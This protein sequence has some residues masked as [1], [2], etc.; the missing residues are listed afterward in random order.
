MVRRAR[1]LALGG[2]TLGGLTLPACSLDFDSFL[3]TPEEVPVD[4][5]PVLDASTDIGIVPDE[6]PPPDMVIE[7]TDTDGDGVDDDTDNCPDVPNLDQ[8]DADGDGLGDLCD[9]DRDGD[10]VTN[11]LDNCPDLPNPD[12]LDLDGDGL[13]DAC[14]DDIDGD[15]L[16]NAQELTQGTDA[17]RPDTDADGLLDGADNCPTVPDRLAIDTD[18]DG[19]GD[20][21]DL[22][23][24]G[25]G[26]LDWADNC[27]RTVN[28]DQGDACVNDI[29]GDGV[30][31]DVDSCPTVANPDQAITPCVSRFATVGYVRDAYGLA[32]NDTTT[33]AATYGGALRIT[34]DDY[35]TLNNADGLVGNRLGRAVFDADGRA[36]FPT[37]RG[38]AVLRPD[39]VV[40][41]LPRLSAEG[42]QGQLRDVVADAGG[43]L[44]VATDNGLWLLSPQGLWSP[45]GP[46]QIPDNDVRSLY[47]DAQDRIWVATATGVVR[48]EG[49]QLQPALAGLPAVAPYT[50]VV[51]DGDRIWLLGEAGA[52][53]L[54]LADDAVGR[55]FTGF[56]ARGVSPANGGARYLATD[57]GI[58]R[59]D[60]D[61]RLFP[62]N[63]AQLPDP[64]VRDVRGAADAPRWL[65]TAGGVL[66]M[67]GHFSALH[68]AE[69]MPDPCVTRG[70]RI[71][72]YL[73]VTAPTGLFRINAD[74]VAAQVPPESLPAADTRVLRQ[75]ANGEVWVGTTGG[76]GVFADDGTP[77]R[78]LTN[79]DG[80]PPGTI[81][82]II[83]GANG[84]VWVASAANGVARRDLG[85]VWT[86]YTAETV[87]PAGNFVSNQVRAMAYGD[88]RVFVGTNVG[89]SVYNQAQDRFDPPVTNQNGV[90][91]SADINDLTSAGGTI[92]AGTEL[93]ISVRQP[94]GLWIN[95]FRN[96]GGLPLAAATDA[97]LA[98]AA[99][100]AYVWAVTRPVPQQQPNGTLVRR[101]V[102]AELGDQAAMQLFTADNAGLVASTL[103][104]GAA[105]D[106]RDG[107]LFISHCGN[108]QSP[109]GLTVLDGVRV[110]PRTL[111][112]VGV[113]G[114]AGRPVALVRGPDNRPAF[115]TSPDADTTPVMIS[116]GADG[117]RTTQF[118]PPAV[119]G[120]P[121][122]CD[123]NL[124]NASS[125]WCALGTKG[126]VQRRAPESWQ[127][128]R[129]QIRVLADGEARDI[130]VE[131]DVLVVVATNLGAVLLEDRSVRTFNR[132]GTAGGLPDDDVR[133]VR[134]GADGRLYFGTAAGVGIYERNTRQWTTI[135]V[136]V[137]ANADVRAL[138]VGPDGTV[139]VGT[140]SGVEKVGADLTSQRRIGVADGLPSANVTGIVV[141]GGQVYV[142]TEGG[143]ATGDGNGA[144]QVLG[145]ADGL[146]G[147]AVRNLLVDVDGMVW[148]RSDDGIARLLTP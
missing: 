75:L 111:T 50:R 12:Q 34:A 113:P 114:G 68:Q 80:I 21:C 57:A 104:G 74:G 59:V 144:F 120:L 28:A 38:L 136:D 137:L 102:D 5:G 52:T 85:G 19:R 125:V 55:T 6:G 3:E 42:P 116:I 23:D 101:K 18:N 140:P 31:D 91:F 77:I 2:L 141:N 128:I 115:V 65:A 64:R 37:D 89:I 109:G 56:A 108:A 121:L 76:V 93:G 90:L 106:L 87:L 29:D 145:F 134:I 15:G 119:Q 33:Y 7:V 58:R 100:G 143:L 45:V 62:A 118:V 61:G 46:P 123:V 148:V 82:D 126:I 112:A 36:W 24:D 67:D 83:D 41:G 14:D 39:G 27:V 96:V 63:T 92:Y 8:A 130:A 139:W 71:G 105:L 127:P 9:D 47:R 107:E 122:A 69:G 142:G 53:W 99:D 103:A 129:D 20:A 146:P 17:A 95:W 86:A 13:G 1:W 51:G 97:V 132:A 44:W 40:L 25:D 4:T 98:V 131:S 66:Q 60:A 110:V 49:G 88:D 48:A 73:W 117:S 84:E 35:Q 135:G 78:T 79:A 10:E 81:T 54:N 94:G 124:A 72:G 70:A 138:A 147:T 26:V 11:D 43:S 30:A 32:R 133:V 16:L 22:D